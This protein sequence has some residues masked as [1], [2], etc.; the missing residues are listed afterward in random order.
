MK[1]IL[2]LIF[3]LGSLGNLHQAFAKEADQQKLKKYLE[4]LDVSA[5]SYPQECEIINSFVKTGTKSS[6]ENIDNLNKY[7]RK[8]YFQ[9][10]L[11]NSEKCSIGLNHKEVPKSLSVDREW[12]QETKLIASFY[13]GVLCGGI[14]PILSTKMAQLN[15]EA[16]VVQKDSTYEVTEGQ[17]SIVVD[18]KKNTLSVKVSSSSGKLKQTNITYK[19]EGAILRP[20]DITVNTPHNGQRIENHLE[21]GTKLFPIKVKAKAYTQQ[22]VLNGELLLDC[23]SN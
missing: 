2:S 11:V 21:F 12:L 20:S 19:R 6:Q 23:H 22:K 14:I 9:L 4:E 3:I 10:H 18:T 8:N 16:K 5:I 15:K 17:D 1:L 13:E 7:A